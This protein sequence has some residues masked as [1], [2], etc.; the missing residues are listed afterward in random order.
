MFDPTLAAR[1][2]GT[3]QA[4]GLRLPTDAESMMRALKAPDAAA[5]TWPVPVF[6][7]HLSELKALRDLGAAKRK[8]SPGEAA[9]AADQALRSARRKFRR[10][11]VHGARQFLARGAFAE[12]GFRE[13]L[14]WFWSDHFTAATRVPGLR[15]IGAAYIEEA[16]RPNIT[17]RFAELLWAVVTHPMMLVYLDQHV[18]AGPST[19]L[20]KRRGRGLNENL[21][22]EI[23]ELHTLGVK[24][25]YRQEDVRALAELLTGLTV[26]QGEGFM[27]RAA[28]AEPGPERILGK[29]YGGGAPK[30]AH[31]RLAIEDLA[32]HPDT[33]Q[34][35]AQKLAVHFV[36]DTPDP[37]LTAYMADQFL[38]SGGDLMALYAA[39]L[40][41]PG[42]W[43]PVP[44]NA[45]PPFDFL[46]SSIRA[47]TV[48]ERAIET[49]SPK[50]LQRG[51][52]APLQV[53]GQPWLQPDGPD[54]FSE[55]DGA[56]VT[57]QG[58]AGR[59]S[60]AMTM[61]S[62]LLGKLPDP[63][64]FVL[65]ALGPEADPRTVFA[66]QAAENRAEGIGLVLMSPRFQRR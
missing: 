57:P 37:A 3:G 1:R 22:R 40:E 12:D 34:H 28:M 50:D 42:A 19:K 65:S 39:L 43:S 4:T 9:K 23:L 66:A 48:P 31:I 41:H 13:R 33:A 51:F 11:R 32:A 16:I 10:H 58:L 47:L 27:F 53:M 21:A 18:S 44:R 55:N 17:G 20:G 38:K 5:Q 61:P 63:R 14:T 8:A 49:L 25:Q 35:L 64:D 7:E 29:T 60:W 54:G 2:F 59:I 46:V 56:W 30:L 26:K 6:S 36:S 45:V 24:G 62:R 15:S 52:F